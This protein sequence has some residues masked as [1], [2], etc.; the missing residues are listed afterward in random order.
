MNDFNW[1]AEWERRFDERESM[2][3]GESGLG[4]WEARADD[5]SELRV[6]R[7][8]EYGRK[9]WKIVA[10]LVSADA[11]VLD[12]GAGP[13]T[14]LAPF[15]PNVGQFTAV[16]P[17]ENMAALLKKNA[18]I[19]GINNYQLLQLPWQDMNMEQYRRH[20]DLV[21]ISI[22]LW[23]FRDIWRQIERLEQVCKGYCCVVTGAGTDPTGGGDPLWNKVMGDRPKPS[24]SELLLLFNLLHANGRLPEVKNFSYIGERN[25]EVKVRQQKLFYSKYT[26]LTPE[27]EDIIRNYEEKR[28]NNGIVKENYTAAIVSWK[29]LSV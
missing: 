23:M 10:P 29:P 7:E 17:A 4:Y 6:S 3:T 24:Y 20:F 2:Y 8:Y 11:K 5:F 9:V 1:I 18:E 26:A 27:Q 12:V 21:V 15:A 13:G 19:A 25:I 28:A 14:F 22:T 16:E